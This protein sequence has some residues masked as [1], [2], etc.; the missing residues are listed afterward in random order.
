[1]N[2][3]FTEL[4][5]ALTDIVWLFT[6]NLLTVFTDTWVVYC[7]FDCFIY[8]FFQNYLIYLLVD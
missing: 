4:T 7:L 5:A 6:V 3:W 2:D 8:F 1:M